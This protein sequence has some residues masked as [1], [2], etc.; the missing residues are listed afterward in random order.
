MQYPLY[1]QQVTC[2]DCA[3][4]VSQCLHA[5]NI[6]MTSAW[7]YSGALPTTDWCNVGS[8]KAYLLSNGYITY[9]VAL[10]YCLCGDPF[11]FA[12]ITT[13]VLEHT[14]FMVYND[15]TTFKYDAHTNDRLRL[16]WTGTL[17]GYV[18]HYAHVIY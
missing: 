11:F 16:N 4:F 10:K 15:G 1:G 5:G 6:P 7:N 9:G 18:Y 12:N 13:G 14:V 8:L 3:D 2:N 17:G